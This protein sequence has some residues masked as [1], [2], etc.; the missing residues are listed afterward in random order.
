M[1]LGSDKTFFSMER[2]QAITIELVR[3][4][5]KGNVPGYENAMELVSLAEKEMSGTSVKDE[6]HFWSR[7]SHSSSKIPRFRIASPDWLLP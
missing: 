2:Y 1:S 5:P 7:S 6:R 3:T 4:T